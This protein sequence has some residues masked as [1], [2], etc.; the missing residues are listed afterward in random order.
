MISFI[1]VDKMNRIYE[2]KFYYVTGELRCCELYS[3]KVLKEVKYWYLNGS[4]NK[5]VSYRSGKVE[6]VKEWYDNGRSWT[7]EF[8]K[9][10]KRDGNYMVWNVDGMPIVKAHNRSG[11]VNGK[12]KDWNRNVELIFRAYW[13]MGKCLDG[14]FTLE[15]ECVFTNLKKR[16]IYHSRSILNDYIITDLFNLIFQ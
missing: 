4:V 5:Q 2:R 1:I 8:Y 9:N 15:K 14:K 10:E 13:R 12:S 7:H 11:L 6:E 16:F 3:G